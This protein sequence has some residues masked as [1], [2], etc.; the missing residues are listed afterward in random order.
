MSRTKTSVLEVNVFLCSVKSS[1]VK[2]F[3]RNLVT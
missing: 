3:L 1:D 2:S